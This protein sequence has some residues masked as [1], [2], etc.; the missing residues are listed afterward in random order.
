MSNYCRYCGRFVGAIFLHLV[1]L[2]NH[3]TAYGPYHTM[4]YTVPTGYYNT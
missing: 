2:I 4:G 1:G 3:G